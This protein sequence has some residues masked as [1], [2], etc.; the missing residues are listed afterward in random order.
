ME[1]LATSVP[2]SARK[3]EQV[4]HTLIIKNNGPSAAE[5][6]NLKEEIGP[7]LA[8]ESAAGSQG[9]CAQS[10]RSNGRVI[11]HLGRMPA[12]S[13]VTVKIVTR[14]QEKALLLNNT[15][16]VGNTAELVFKENKTDFIEAK[17][18]MFV[19]FKTVIVKLEINSVF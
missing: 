13:I 2:E 3:G 1:L 7:D 11:C 14:V 19:E 16:D 4:T 15:N 9:T 18:Q 5:E 8:F 10:I 17:H 12:G 6:V